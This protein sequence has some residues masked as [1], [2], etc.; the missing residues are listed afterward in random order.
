MCSCRH[1]KSLAWVT[2]VVDLGLLEN[3]KAVP[4]LSVLNYKLF[5]YI[6]MILELQLC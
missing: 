4:N 2:S 6:I 3:D 5:R 1:C